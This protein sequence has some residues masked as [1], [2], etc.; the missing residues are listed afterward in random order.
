MAIKDPQAR[1]LYDWENQWGA[2]WTTKQLTQDE[3]REAIAHASLMYD[4]PLPAIRFFKGARGSTYYDPNDHSINLRPRHMNLA[5]CLHE[6]AHAVHSHVCGDEGEH[7]I[8]GPE[9]FAIY[10][11]LL[12]SF[13]VAPLGALVAFA[14][15]S[16][17]RY[18]DPSRHTPRR[19]RATYRDLCRRVAAARDS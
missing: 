13:D 18:A 5:I 16:G 6:T 3:C 4:M 14:D 2:K 7:E 11:N 8:H 17:L 12:S 10:L 19:L 9:W 15:A 1:R